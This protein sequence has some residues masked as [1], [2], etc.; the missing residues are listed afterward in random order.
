L[1]ET[2]DALR[3]FITDAPVLVMPRSSGAPI[4]LLVLL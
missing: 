4:Q 2:A 3:A 1:H